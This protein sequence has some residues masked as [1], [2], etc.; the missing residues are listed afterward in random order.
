MLKINRLRVELNTNDGMYGI[1]EVF[2]TGLNFIASEDNTCGKSSVIEAIYYALG[3]EEIIGGKGE[4]VLTSAYK[5]YLEVNSKTINILE[6]KIFLEIYNGEDVITL[7]RAAKMSNRDTKLITVYYSSLDNIAKSDTYIE[8]MYVHMKNSATNIK[9]FHSFLENFLNLELP[10][11]PSFDDKERKLYLQL[12]FS[13]M[14]I[15]QKHGWG[16]ILSGIP[17]LGI[18]NSKKRV[19]EFVLN[20]D[21]LTNEKKKENLKYKENQITN[22]WKYEYKELFNEANKGNCTILNLSATPCILNE[23]E[24]DKICVVNDGEDISQKLVYLKDEFKKLDKLKPQVVDNFDDLQEELY[25]IES[26]IEDYEQ[27]IK[28][29]RNNIYMEEFSI[30]S[31]DNNIEIIDADLRNNNDAAKLRKLGSD[32]DSRAF[33]NICP[34]CEQHID[35]TL[36]PL[37]DGIEVMSIDENIRHLEAQRSMLIYAKDSHKNANIKNNQLLQQLQGAVFKL[38]RLA[39]AIRN[40]LYSVDESISEAI[41]Y[42]KNELFLTIEKLEELQILVDK[43]KK[44]FSRLSLEWERLLESKSNLPKNKFSDMDSTK[45][46]QLRDEF[47]NNIEKYG[48]GSVAKTNMNEIE[49]SEDNYLPVIEEF[50]MKFDSSASDNIRAIWAYTVALMQTSISRN[51]N[52]QNMLIFDEPNQHSIVSNDMREFFNSIINLQDECQIIIGITIKDSDTKAIIDELNK[53]KYNLIKIEEKAFKK[54]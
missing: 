54:L 29:V 50:D 20:L 21:T 18:K 35:D 27:K 41:M 15:E 3:F 24:V 13:C 34:V 40:D 31:L 9:G 44:T 1:D 25:A 10:M 52:H 32:L 38:R 22:N 26:E 36:L 42:K 33:K 5:N 6:S 17:Y 30:K 16:D 53:E 45:I 23:S 7:Y 8:D 48:Y 49:I 39:M 51:G 11:V 28:V 19:I 43:K 14:F 12:I 47:V 37:I 46:K 4:K 2:N